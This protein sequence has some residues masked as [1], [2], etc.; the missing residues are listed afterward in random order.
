MKNPE[1]STFKSRVKWN[2]ISSNLQNLSSLCFSSLKIKNLLAFQV[3]KVSSSRI[4][5]RD[6]FQHEKNRM[7][8]QNVLNG[9]KSGNIISVEFLNKPLFATFICIDSP[10]RFCSLIFTL[11][12][13]PLPPP[14]SIIKKHRPLLKTSFLVYIW[15]VKTFS[16][17]MV[18]FNFSC[19]LFCFIRSFP[20][21]LFPSWVHLFI[22]KSWTRFSSLCI[23]RSKTIMMGLPSTTLESSL[24]VEKTLAIAKIKGGNF[25]IFLLVVE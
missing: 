18:C 3:F 12:S 17:S 7:R 23:A 8:K 25:P 15:C 5:N 4:A 14:T 13:I 9:K 20:I 2:L 19:V 21:P 11:V 16:F 22:Q 6:V 10:P 1:I 24:V